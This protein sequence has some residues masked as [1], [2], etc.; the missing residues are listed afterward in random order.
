[1]QHHITQDKT[2]QRHAIQCNRT[3]YNLQCNDDRVQQ[4]KAQKTISYCNAVKYKT[5]EHNELYIYIYNTTQNNFMQY[6]RTKHNTAEHNTVHTTQ[7]HTTQCIYRFSA[8]F[9]RLIF[10]G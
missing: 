10:H 8:R 7:L 9:D 6:N 4:S 3:Q 5:T 2:I 1:M